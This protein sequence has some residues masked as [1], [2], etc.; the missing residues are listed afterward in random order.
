M[1][2]VRAPVVLASLFLIRCPLLASRRLILCSAATDG[3]LAFWDLTTA[4]DRGSTT[5][6]LPAHPGLPYRKYPDALITSHTR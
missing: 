3:S 4:M 5:L 1:G 2:W 6:E